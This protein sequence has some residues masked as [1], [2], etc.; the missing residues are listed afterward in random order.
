[1]AAGSE[2]ACAI[3]G[4]SAARGGSEDCGSVVSEDDEASSA[5]SVAV[6]RSH[7]S[8]PVKNDN[9]AAEPGAA[10]SDNSETEGTRPYWPPAQD[11]W[12]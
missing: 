2:G 5:V 9:D 12:C 8:L 10:F 7:D 3:R 6:L 1:M 4:L 11:K